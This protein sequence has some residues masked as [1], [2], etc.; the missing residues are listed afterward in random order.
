MIDHQNMEG[1]HQSP[2]QLV[3]IKIRAVLSD[4]INKLDSTEYTC[5]NNIDFAR[6]KI[7]WVCALLLRVG[8]TLE[9]S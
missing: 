8:G 9:S 5:S 3:S 4:V 1:Q 2:F 7:D 6:Y